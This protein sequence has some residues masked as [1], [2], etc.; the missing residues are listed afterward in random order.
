LLFKGDPLNLLQIHQGNKSYATKTIFSDANCAINEGQHIGVIGPNGAGKS[1]LFKILIGQEQL[2][3]GDLIKK[4]NLRI[5]YLE[6]ESDWDISVT[7]KSRL[8]ECPK[9]Y[10]QIEAK[11][12][13]LGLNEELLN[14]PLEKLSGG[15][16]MRT[17][18][19]Y[20]WSLDP[21]L[22]LLD[23]P[24]NFL[25]LETI[26]IL[27]DF[28][29]TYEGAFMLISHDREFLRKTTDHILEVESGELSQYPGNIDDYFEQKAEF[30][31]IQRR[32]AYNQAQKRAALQSFVDRFRAK[33]TKARQAQSRLK[34][35]EKMDKI[36]LKALPVRARI[37]IPEPAAVGRDLCQIE[38]LQIG[39]NHSLL[40][41]PIHLQLRRGQKL[42]I[43]GFNGVGKSTFLKTLSQQLKPIGGQVYWADKVKVGHFSQHSSEQLDLNDSVLEAFQKSAHP[44]LLKQE[45]LDMAGSLLFAGD[46]LNK[47]LKVCSGGE[48]S[49]VALGQIL[50]AKNNVL[51]LDEP[52][53][54]LDFDTVEALTQSLIA[55]EGTL[56]II[57]HDRA[58]IS[59]VAQQILEMHDGV[60]DIYPGTYDEYLWSLQKGGLSHRVSSDLKAK[61]SAA[62]ATPSEPSSATKFNYKAEQKRLD[63]EIL[64]HKKIIKKYESELDTFT[65]SILRLNE[66]ILAEKGTRAQELAIN[67]S[68][69]HQNQSQIE[70]ELLKKM[71]DLEALELELLNLQSKLGK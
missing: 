17:R 40:E 25:D 58:F 49:R 4:S 34:Q 16:R 8:L 13:D 22:M 57:S 61:N 7:A 68:Q 36:D 6:Q 26:L 38:E 46:D 18:L 30:L 15:Y 23:E 37:K 50:L 28:L 21:E 12:S 33:A 3:S 19:L 32:Q 42:G 24:T 67:L 5:A 70:E 69:I 56:V 54:H 53:N 65:T 44:N 35:L 1:T 9:P 59:R 62:V 64:T 43:V 66:Q 51:L 63:T 55:F 71:E 41:K 29:Q 45:I 14:T 48:K 11:A 60:L 27:E 10:W 47:P 31:E 39:Y 2:D 52:T 20:L